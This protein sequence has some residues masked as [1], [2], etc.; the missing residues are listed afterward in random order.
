MLAREL[1]EGGDEWRQTKV[2]CSQCG[3]R[4]LVVRRDEQ[5]IAFRCLGCTPDS[6]ATEY[7][8]GNPLFAR[9]VGEVVRP[10][11]ILARAADWSRRYYEDGTD[12]ARAQCTRCGRGVRLRPYV[13]DGRRGLH[14]TCA[15]CG[16]QVSSSLAGLAGAQPEVRRLRR[17]H[18]QVRALPEREIGGKVVVRYESLRG[19]DGVDVLFARDSL[20]VVAVQI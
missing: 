7:R 2:W 14:A 19:R 9:L 13:R 4:R 15:A 11:A 10:S 16:E 12:A 3:E 6:I 1:G 17:E 18:P 5:S 8:L 20:R